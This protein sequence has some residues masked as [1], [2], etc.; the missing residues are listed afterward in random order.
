M[1]FTKKTKLAAV[2]SLGMA[3]VAMAVPQ[4]LVDGLGD[5]NYQLREK[6]EK[7]LIQWAK[8]KG[9][10]GVKDLSDLKKRT[11]SPEV[12][13]RLEN[14]ISGVV[15][16]KAIPNT[17]GYMGI[18]LSPKP[19]AVGIDRVVAKT[20]ADKSGLQPGD[21]I[22]WI[23]GIDLSKKRNHAMEAMTFVQRYVKTK[24]AGEKLTLK[25]QRDGRELTKNLKLADYD[26]DIAGLGFNNRGIQGRPV[27]GRQL[28]GG[29]QLRIVPQPAKRPKANPEKLE[30]DEE[31]QL[32]LEIRSPMKLLNRRGEQLDAEE[33]LKL[34]NER[35]MQ[36]LKKLEKEQELKKKEEPK[37]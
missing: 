33:M 9:E 24:N 21:E 36:K 7:E 29:M 31:P 3:G 28:R 14:V 35:N 10:E 11:Q 20:P 25:I 22:T 27:P 19:G 12:L 16:Y 23:D 30:Q 26:K 2:L 13:S 6:S 18:V 5:D 37:Q 4:E 8:K 17:R 34:L 15:V 1:N 32:K